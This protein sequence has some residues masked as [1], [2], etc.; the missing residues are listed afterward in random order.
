ME[1][2]RRHVAGTA[3]LL[4]ALPI[5]ALGATGAQN[6]RRQRIIDF[7]TEDIDQAQVIEF[8]GVKGGSEHNK[9]E[10]VSSP[11][12]AGKTAFKHWVDQQ[13]ERS[14]LAMKRV[15]IG[16]TNWY[17]WSMQIPEDFDPAGHHTNVAQWASYPTVAGRRFPGGAN[18]HQMRFESSGELTYTLHHQGAGTVKTAQGTEILSVEMQKYV[19]SH[20]DRMKGKWADFVMHA[21]WTG[22]E[23]G[24]LELWI[25][26]GDGPYERK[27]HHKGRT[28]WN[29]EGTGPYFKMGAYL[30]DPGWKGK[31]PKVLYT[32]EYRLGTAEAGFDAVAPPGGKAGK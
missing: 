28:W 19:L 31:P 27:I 30:G 2:R 21:K 9:L 17:G 14:E 12:R 24:F 1:I 32:D 5:L 18:G 13:G 25:K 20:S 16:D 10:N 6:E 8:K 7:C 29:D 11:V 15:K 4:C 23:D 22:H 26:I 3:L